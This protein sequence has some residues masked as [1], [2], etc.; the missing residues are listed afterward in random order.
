MKTEWESFKGRQYKRDAR[1]EARVTLGAKGTIYL[2]GV[3][4]D[5]L[6]RP[7]AVEMLFNGNRRMIGLKP[8]DPSKDNAF[9]VKK[10]H[11]NYH[12]ISAAAFCQTLRLKFPRTLL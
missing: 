11:G 5:A 2:N 7:A 1:K 9:I 10:H 4:Y 6:D 12:R 3:A 8:I